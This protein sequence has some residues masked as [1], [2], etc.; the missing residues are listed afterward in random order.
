MIEANGSKK[1]ASLVEK[2][3]ANSVTIVAV[4]SLP[5]D[6]HLL[7]VLAYTGI[8]PQPHVCWFFNKDIG[9]FIEGL[10]S[11]KSQDAENAYRA[12]MRRYDGVELPTRYWRDM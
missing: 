2:A 8:Q 6:P 3:K 10:Y 5:N 9:G 7:V 4:A 11:E 1:P 12:R